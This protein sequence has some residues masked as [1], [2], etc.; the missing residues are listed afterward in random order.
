MHSG[1]ESSARIDVDNHLPLILR[2]HLLPGRNNQ[3]IIHIELME[4]LLPVVDPIYV[5]S[6]GFL[7]STWTQI[8]KFPHPGKF[9][10]NLGKN[11]VLILPFF[12]IEIDKCRPIIRYCLRKN[13]DKHLLLFLLCKRNLVLNLHSLDSKV[14]K[15]TANNILCRSSRL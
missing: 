14:R 2:F 11:S 13:I 9:L 10:Q 4:I 12:Q 7:N 15:N 5:L 8:H 6:L 3:D 1:P